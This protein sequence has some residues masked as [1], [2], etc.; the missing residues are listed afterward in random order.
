MALHFAIALKHLLARKRQS[1]VSLLGI[2]L[3]VAFFLAIS[4][5]MKGSENDFIRRL[6]DNSPHI[7]V[8]DEFR[9]PRLQPL[10][11]TYKDG[12]VELRN[13]SP[14]REP[15]GIRG[16]NQIIQYIRD[17]PGARASAS[18]TGE[19]VVNYAG[20]DYGLSLNG[21]VPKEMRDVT[22]IQ[23]YMLEGSLENLISDP[24]G[25]V[26]GSEFAKRLSLDMN[27]T[28]TVTASSGIVRTFRIVGIFRIGRSSYDRG[29]AFVDLKRVQALLGRSSRANSI[30][31]K[32]PDPQAAQTTAAEIE[33]QFGYKSVSWQEAS[34]D[35]MN[36][37]AIRNTIMYTVVSAVLV[38][39]A[40]GIYNVISTV[41]MEKQRDIAILK[42]MGFQA[43]E[44][45]RIFLIQGV[46]LGI[47]GCLMGLPLGSGFMLALM[48]VRL[49][50]PG[51]TEIVN[52]P[53]DW[54]LTQ[55]LI[56]GAFALCAATLAA[57]LP[58]RKAARVQPVDILRGGAG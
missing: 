41:V 8:Q 56:A 7:T 31:V 39:A 1:F 58:A 27:D 48:Q 16:Y 38:V 57:W 46:I 23:D 10:L 47:F 24:G 49:K 43:W 45:Q 26:V 25:I 30:L 37:L 29:Q 6:V 21:M 3:G 34:E 36:T 32:L 33:R 53:L 42:S 2:I 5:L 19:V 54:G 11:Q 4:S 20:Q 12:A 18:L 22:T 15:R 51:S 14:M 40:F 44:V 50:P 9:E 55:F 52:M 17:I 13:V 28:I 35:I